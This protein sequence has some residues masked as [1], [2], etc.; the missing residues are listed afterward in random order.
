MIR[1]TH[2]LISRCTARPQPIRRTRTI[3]MAA[4][5]RPNSAVFLERTTMRSWGE[6]SISISRRS[7]SHTDLHRYAN[8]SEEV[9]LEQTD[10]DLVELVHR[11]GCPYVRV[12]LIIRASVHLL[13][14]AGFAPTMWKMAQLQIVQSLRLTRCIDSRTRTRSTVDART[15]L[16]LARKHQ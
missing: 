2:H 7:L 6:N 4:I 16:R 1:V 5:V 10:H 14:A 15:R 9:E 3:G 8:E 13:L 12:Q 11:C